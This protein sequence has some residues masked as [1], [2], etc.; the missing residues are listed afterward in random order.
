MILDSTVRVRVP[1]AH[2]VI[3]DVVEA[4]GDRIDR[5]ALS[6]PSLEDVYIQKTGHRFWSEEA[7]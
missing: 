5:V 1:N 4:F 6:H 3:G 2:R 7:V